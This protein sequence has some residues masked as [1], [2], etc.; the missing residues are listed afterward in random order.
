MLPEKTPP[1]SAG[2]VGDGGRSL[3]RLV[4]RT[5]PSLCR[6]SVAVAAPRV[7]S[8]ALSPAYARVRL[9]LLASRRAVIRLRDTRGQAPALAVQA[10]RQTFRQWWR[11]R[12][13]LRSPP[14]ASLFSLR[15]RLIRACSAFAAAPSRAASS[16]VLLP[17]APL[18]RF[19]P[20]PEPPLFPAMPRP[21]VLLLCTSWPRVVYHTLPHLV[22]WP[23]LGSLPYPFSLLSQLP[24]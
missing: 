2:G 22:H 20:P 21:R 24:P 7:T 23:R 13:L 6:A 5:R 17:C 12:L 18:S 16:P 8:P 1:P 19:S 4:L 15:S 10:T 14:A 9:A 11:V 3:S